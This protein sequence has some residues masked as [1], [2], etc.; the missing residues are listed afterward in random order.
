MIVIRLAQLFFAHCHSSIAS[1]RIP[2]I[3]NTEDYYFRF[4]ADFGSWLHY[5]I[6]IGVLTLLHLAADFITPL[7]VPLAYF[8][9]DYDRGPASRR[10]KNGSDSCNFEQFH[11]DFMILSA[12]QIHSY[13]YYLLNEYKC[14]YLTYL[15]AVDLGYQYVAAPILWCQARCILWPPD[16]PILGTVLFIF[17]VAVHTFIFIRVMSRALL[18]ASFPLPSLLWSKLQGFLSQAVS[19]FLF[20]V[21][22]WVTRKL[23]VNE[24]LGRTAIRSSYYQVRLSVCASCVYNTDDLAKAG[25]VVNW[26][27]DSISAVLDNSANTHVWS[28]IEDFA[29]GSLKYFG[30]SDDVGVMTIGDETSRPLGM[31]LVPIHLLD[32]SGNHCDLDLVEALFFPDSPVNIISV[33][34]LASQFEDLDGTWI[35]TRWRSSTFTWN[36]EKHTLDFMHPPSN[37]PIIQ[38]SPGFKRYQSLC[39]LCL[40]CD[41][42]PQPSAMLTCQTYL[43]TDQYKDV[44]LATDE[45]AS[46]QGDPRFRFQLK[47]NLENIFHVGD[48]LRYTNNGSAQVV[49]V[50][51]VNVNEENMITYFDILLNDGHTITVTKDFLAP[52]EDDDIAI[53]PVTPDQVQEHIDRL[54]PEDVEG[55]LRRTPLTSPLSTNA[56]TL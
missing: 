8:W 54:T 12:Y 28:R 26:D 40:D 53:I 35:K 22:S 33:T 6:G 29:E 18:L 25:D 4:V 30:D 37:L 10:K 56:A 32:N 47:Q 15:S 20:H 16:G 50:V 34:K 21:G 3:S 19:L 43:P 1:R 51:G 5:L 49:E 31:G 48:K 55:L 13:C 9:F 24:F 11:S 52:L 45:I 38:V 41:V 7:I 39:T 44:C 2:F 42:V 27:S 14:W 46:A 17:V 23:P 36:S